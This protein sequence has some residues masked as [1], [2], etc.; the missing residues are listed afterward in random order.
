[1]CVDCDRETSQCVCGHRLS[2]VRHA[3]TII[4]MERGS[5]AELGTHEQLLQLDGVY[6][7]LF[8]AQ[9]DQFCTHLQ[10]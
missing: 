9:V 1:M 6:S 5:V 4:V 10:S 3:D 2:T 8:H 7:D